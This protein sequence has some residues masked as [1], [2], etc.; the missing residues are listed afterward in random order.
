[1]ILSKTDYLLFRECKKSTWLKIHKPDIYY[2][3]ELSAFAKLLIKT[4]NEVELVARK[5][6]PSGIL[7]EGRDSAAQALTQEH[8]QKKQQVLFQAVFEKDGFF[9]AVDILQFN[10][11]TNKYSI[12]EVKSTNDIDEKTHY[13]D[14]AFQVNLLRKFG[15]II[16]KMHLVHLDKEYVFRDELNFVGLFQIDDISDKINSLCEEVLFE[17]NSALTYLSQDSLPKGHCLCVYKGRSNHCTCF[18]VLNPD[19]PEYSVHDIVRIGLSKKKLEDMVDGKIFH[20]DKIPPHITLSNIQQNQI[21][22]Y[23]L[24][25]IVIDK[26]RM[27]KELKDLEFPLYFIDYETLPCAIPRFDGFSPYHHIPFQ[28]SLYVLTTPEAKPVLLEFLYTDGNDPTTHFVKSLEKH[29]G[30]SGSI[31]VWHK[32]FECGRN[33]E[34]AIRNPELKEYI[35]SL[36]ARV[37]DLEDIFKK[38]YYVHKDFKGSTSI[39]KVLP[40]LVPGLSYKDLDIQDGGSAAEIWNKLCVEKLSKNEKEKIVTSL[41]KYCGLDAYAVYSIWRELYKIIG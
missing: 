9:A 32:S 17:M 2:Q 29:I 25:S 19:V 23:K 24:D 39:K 33:S 36:N 31:T 30:S 18:S 14:L 13:Y 16:E 22:T 27:V 38:Q 20:I 15:L 41:K 21:N 11:E 40:V 37:F 12:Y 7:I 4:G 34:M 35:D 6:F 26:E 10:P 3:H 5:R 1:M 8:I 28:Y